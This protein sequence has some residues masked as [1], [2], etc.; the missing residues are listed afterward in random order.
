MTRTKQVL[1]VA[2]M[3]VAV[4]GFIAPAGAE[5]QV[6]KMATTTSTDNTGLLDYLAPRFKQD[7]GVELQWV[8]VGTGKA[9][10]LGRNC[11]VDVLLVH[12]PAAEKKFV[13]EGHGVDRRQVMYN[14]FVVIGPRTDPAQVRGL[15]VAD[16]MKK[17]ARDK[18]IFVSR[19]DDSGTN[20]KE[21]G[22]W[23]KAG[24]EGIDKEAWYVQTG[25]GMMATINVA[26]ERNGYTL[27]DRGTYI[28]YENNQKGN[29]PLVILV[30]GDPGLFNQYSVIPINPAKCPDTKFDLAKK[31]SDWMASEPIQQFIGDFKLLDKQLFIPNAK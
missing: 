21:I 25:Q 3:F 22:L 8:S 1:A 30:E 19:G 28:T 29:P 13:E 26:A 9:L 2:L 24:I 23:K 16:A 10:E 31:Y 15:A 20:K 6:L 5:N 14:D 4:T 27:T 18:A 17:M 12:A 11:D 7:T